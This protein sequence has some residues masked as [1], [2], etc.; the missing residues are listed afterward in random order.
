MKIKKKQLKPHTVVSIDIQKAF[1]T[2]S[3]HAIERAPRSSGIDE[4]TS[5]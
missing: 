4:T 2:V 5:N 1:D 3:H